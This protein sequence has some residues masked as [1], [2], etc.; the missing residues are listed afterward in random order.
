M[1]VVMLDCTRCSLRA[2]RT[3]PPSSTTV[4]KICR[5]A[6]SM[7][8]APMFFDREE[9]VLN[10]SVSE[11]PVQAYH[12]R[13]ETSAGLTT[14]HAVW[15]GLAG[16]AAAMGVGRFAFTPLLPLMQADGLTLAQGAW[17]AGANYLGYLMGALA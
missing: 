12:D 1:R 15:T 11:K 2:A 13:M 17:L 9:L 7:A 6:R 14:R 3:M 4:L 5:S 16:L 10:Y 8:R